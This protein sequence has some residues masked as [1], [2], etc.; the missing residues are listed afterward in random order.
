MTE[1]AVR[2]LTI[3]VEEWF[4]S[5]ALTA[6][7]DQ[8]R[9]KSAGS[10]LVEQTSWLLD[11][12]GEHSI[13]AT[14]FTLGCIARKHPRLI[15]RIADAGHEIAC[16]GDNH[17]PLTKKEPSQ[18]RSELQAA[19]KSLEDAG[20]RKITGFRAPAFSLN[21]GTA[22]AVDILQE[23]GFAY[24]SSIASPLWHPNY[25]AKGFPPT[26]FRLHG[27]TEMPVPSAFGLPVGGGYFRALPYGFTAAQLR[28]LSYGVFYF[29]PWELDRHALPDAIPWA[30]KLRHQAGLATTR[31]KLR[32]LV[33][34]FHFEKMEAC[35]PPPEHDLPRFSFPAGNAPH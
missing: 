7:L 18:F 22:W 5:T 11:L 32:R 19:R 31:R 13:S 24:D 4:H 30:R 17:A 9:E 16:H 21:V 2:I 6:Y 27:L 29:H 3:D 33:R 10:D 15:A 14:F 34:D 8:N 23:L 1:K 12:L 28:S 35:L 25:G 26:P 20:G